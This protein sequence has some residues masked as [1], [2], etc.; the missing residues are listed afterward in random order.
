MAAI[1]V[2]ENNHVL[3]SV[4]SGNNDKLSLNGV[5]RL[6]I[7]SEQILFKLMINGSISVIFL[8]VIVKFLW[9]TKLVTQ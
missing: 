4:L 9:L 6:S 7:Q 5:S 2:I 8:L 3:P 1:K